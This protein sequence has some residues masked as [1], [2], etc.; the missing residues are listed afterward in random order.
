MKIVEI[1]PQ[2][3]DKKKIKEAAEI[4]KKGGVVI[5]PTDTVYGIGAS[6]FNAEAANRIYKIKGREKKKPLILFIGYKK[7]L[8][9]FVTG[10]TEKGYGFVKKF[11]P[12]PLTL[13]FKTSKKIPPWLKDERGTMGVRIPDHPV[14]LALVRNSGPMAT[15]SANISGYKSAKKTGNIPKRLLEEVDLVMDG[16][17][18]P[19]GKESTILDL[20][21]EPFMVLRKGAI[22]IRN[23]KNTVCLH[24]K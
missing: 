11:W 22:P 15:T 19:V 16:G 7:D 17:S 8:H 21:R 4:I 13:I 18:V 2:K 3:P 9:N 10:V 23:E 1:S 14:P 24:R 6:A 5:F 20:T 12:G